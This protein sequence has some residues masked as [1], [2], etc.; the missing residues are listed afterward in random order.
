MSKQNEASEW[1]AD[2]DRALTDVPTPIPPR[3]L[4]DDDCNADQKR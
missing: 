4:G 2:N 1:Q 3:Y